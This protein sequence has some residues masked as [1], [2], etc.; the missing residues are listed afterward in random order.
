MGTIA[1]SYEKN[2]KH[3]VPGTKWLTAMCACTCS[4]KN[5]QNQNVPGN[6]SSM[7]DCPYDA[8]RFIRATLVA[9]TSVIAQGSLTDVF[10]S[11]DCDSEWEHGQQCTLQ[12]PN[13]LLCSIVVT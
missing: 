8:G 3:A 12:H 2:I 7:L 4:S 9:M 6:P 5:I 1:T 10:P 11:S 13:V